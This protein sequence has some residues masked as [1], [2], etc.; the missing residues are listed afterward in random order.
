MTT[1][2]NKSK[3][4]EDE[5]TY[6]GFK[7]EESEKDNLISNKVEENIDANSCP[8]AQISNV[9]VGNLLKVSF[10]SNYSTRYNK[11][12][13]RVNDIIYGKLNQKSKRKTGI[14]SLEPFSNSAKKLA[15]NYIIQKD[16]NN[17][18]SNTG[19]KVNEITEKIKEDIRKR[20]YPRCDS[21][22]RYSCECKVGYAKIL[23]DFEL[24]KFYNH[25]LSSEEKSEFTLMKI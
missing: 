1:Y 19:Y 13:Y 23:P 24:C 14:I 21:A 25:D 16:G 12:L 2:D 8:N 4:K 10:G 22:F 6:Y 18:L 3:V 9:S 11:T 7:I 20:K 5:N 17:F 15:L